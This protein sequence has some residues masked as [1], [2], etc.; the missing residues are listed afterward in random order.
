MNEC[1]TQVGSFVVRSDPEMYPPKS[2]RTP[3]NSRRFDLEI[4]SATRIR[5]VKGIGVRPPP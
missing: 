3:T 5:Y 1:A 2:K 4:T